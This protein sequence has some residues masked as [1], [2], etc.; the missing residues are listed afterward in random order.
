MVD[1]ALAYVINPRLRH[2]PISRPYVKGDVLHSPEA[3]ATYE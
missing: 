1:I 2:Y 3:M